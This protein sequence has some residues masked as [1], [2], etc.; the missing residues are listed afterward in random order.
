MANCR[1]MGTLLGSKVETFGCATARAVSLAPTL[2]RAR[3]ARV[4]SPR[5]RERP[6]AG[7]FGPAAAAKTTSVRTASWAAREG[8]TGVE[9]REIKSHVATARSS[10]ETETTGTAGTDTGRLRVATT[11]AL[12]IALVPRLRIAAQPKA[13]VARRHA[14]HAAGA[15][16][17]AGAWTAAGATW[18]ETGC[19][20]GAT[21]AVRLASVSAATRRLRQTTKGWPL[22]K[23]CNGTPRPCPPMP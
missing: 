20:V 6:K 15:A 2:C 9:S 22:R 1:F 16:R 21:K 10:A 3:R 7:C 5:G 23:E 17:T 11:F 12:G 18:W 8:V 13:A 19:T 14:G 4:P